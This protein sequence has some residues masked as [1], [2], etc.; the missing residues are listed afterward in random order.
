MEKTQQK[1]FI[2]KMIHF[3]RAFY[4]LQLVFGHLK[5]NLLALFYWVFLFFVVGNSIG[6]K[7]G[8][9][10]LFSSPEYQG[11]VSW[12]S[13]ML[14]GFSIGGFTMAFNMYSY[15]RLGSKYPFLATLSRPFMKFCWNNSLIPIIFSIYYI[16]TFTKFQLAEEFASN[17]MIFKY[18]IA[19]I[20]GFVFYVLIAI[21]YFFPTNKD[22]YIFSGKSVLDFQ[23]EPVGSLFHKK[24]KWSELFKYE[25]DRAYIYLSSFVRLKKSRSIKHYD[26][27][28][29]ERVFAHNRINASLFEIVTVISFV[30]LGM[31]R[32]YPLFALP[33][34]MSLVLLMT[35]IL[36]LFSIFISW[37]R[38][39]TYALL[40]GIFI[41]MNFLSKNSSYFQYKSYV[42]G[43]DYKELVPYTSEHISKTSDD[44]LNIA[45][46]KNKYIAGLNEWKKNTGEKKPKMVIVITSGGGSRS[47]LWTVNVLQ[48]GNT[49]TQGKLMRNTQMISG[50]S[51]GMVGAAYY[52]ELLLSQRLGKNI[53]ADDV[54]YLN[55][56]SK[57]LLNQLSF[58][59]YS[60]DLFIRY[61]SFQIGDNFYTKDRGFSF[62]QQLHRNTNNMMDKPLN[63]Y[64][65]YEQS[66]MIPTMI[67]SPTIVN[68]GKRMLI[69]A[70][71]LAFMTHS[72]GADKSNLSYENIDFQTFF[73]GNMTDSVRFSSV[74]RA[75][76][77][78]PFVLPML[79]LPT[80][81]ETNLMDA[82]FRD[83]Y[84]GK[85]MME[86][87]YEMKSWIQQNTSGVVVV[88]IR[89]SKKIIADE[90]IYDISLINKLI[91]PFGNMY[92][93]FTRTQDF[94]QD[95]LMKIGF[96]SF[97]FPIELISFNLR[98]LK[99]DKIAL[100]WH[101][102]KEEKEKI[103]LTIR[104][105]GN[106]EAMNRLVEVLK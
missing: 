71:S 98:E 24:V 99:K 11:E 68:D 29:L 28:V 94:D 52:R 81:P 8:L 3:L 84:G 51:G 104:S 79:S 4:P 88:Q 100:S 45:N 36:M 53:N 105:E 77:S 57:D 74:L 31:F 42:Y 70:Q 43:L 62:E 2:G 12:L 40:I 9:P 23:D 27:A 83:N 25:K 72:T 101:L 89:D 66:G 61:Q 65:P 50:A 75:S 16:F 64:A 76:A 106:K 1:F 96:Q 60:N 59:M 46:S 73:K 34:G 47:A 21:L 63:S 56:I 82:G 93:N 37:F 30:V 32:E 87:L 10:F 48:Q 91:L 92:A 17:W 19:Y 86:F 67:F 14:M 54:K 41:L 38:Y 22:F 103:K 35:V 44:S 13:F 33:A 7:F 26:A 85:V 49:K 90:N 69:S 6:V 39:W 78:F 18:I 5:Y 95:Q 20:L 15:M 80:T 102:T 55:N 58:S 97:A